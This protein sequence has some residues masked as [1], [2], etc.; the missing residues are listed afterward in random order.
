MATL[1]AAEVTALLLLRLDTELSPEI[2]L[3]SATTDEDEELADD[4]DTE[5]ATIDA[6]VTLLVLLFEEVLL[7]AAV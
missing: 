4:V 6:A 5:P 1:V 7:M 3:L 2:S